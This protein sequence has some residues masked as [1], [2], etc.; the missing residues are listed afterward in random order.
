MVR[1]S[2]PLELFALERVRSPEQN[3]FDLILRRFVKRLPKIF[4]V[5]GHVCPG[6]I[7]LLIRPS[8]MLQ[9]SGR[10]TCLIYKKLAD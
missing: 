5:Q 10:R 3:G 8:A 6:G 4:A 2:S 7:G 1:A 9:L